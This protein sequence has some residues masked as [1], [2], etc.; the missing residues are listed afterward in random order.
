LIREQFHRSGRR[1]DRFGICSLG[2]FGVESFS[3]E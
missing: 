1:L 2:A 3:Q